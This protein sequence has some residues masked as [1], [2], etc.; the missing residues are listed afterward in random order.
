MQDYIGATVS[1][2]QTDL[3]F[4]ITHAFCYDVNHL[5]SNSNQKPTQCFHQ[6]KTDVYGGNTRWP[7]AYIHGQRINIMLVNG[8]SAFIFIFFLIKRMTPSET[9]VIPET[10]GNDYR[11]FC[12]GLRIKLWDMT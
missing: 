4:L 6:A 3:C 10:N 2:K 1:N 9:I 5:S 8:L 12:L 11:A 7:T